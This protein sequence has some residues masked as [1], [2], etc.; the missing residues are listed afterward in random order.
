M[1]RTM[2]QGELTLEVK[3]HFMVKN[4]WEYFVYEMPDKE[5]GIGE[6]LVMGFETEC[7]SYSKDEVAPYLIC[8]TEDLSEVLPASGWKWADNQ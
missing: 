4:M 3:A 2:I 8:Y 6:A 7:G 5:Y 1:S